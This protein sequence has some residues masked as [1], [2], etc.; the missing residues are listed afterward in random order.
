MATP[1]YEAKRLKRQIGTCFIWVVILTGFTEFLG[2]AF[3]AISGSM[4]FAEASGTMFEGS[5]IAL[6]GVWISLVR[7]DLDSAREFSRAA[8][9]LHEEV[10]QPETD[11]SR[12]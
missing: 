7:K 9:D 5:L 12:A 1:S 8:K 6:V 10:E 3:Y 4:L 11:C 2:G